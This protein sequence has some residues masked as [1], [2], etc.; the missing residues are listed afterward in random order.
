MY[1]HVNGISELIFTIFYIQIKC[2]KEATEQEGTSNNV[3]ALSPLTKTPTTVTVNR[4]DQLQN[5]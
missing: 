4:D 3:K 5:D 2:K 1:E